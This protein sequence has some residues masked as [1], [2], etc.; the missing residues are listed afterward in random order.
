MKRIQEFFELLTQKKLEQPKHKKS[1]T[2]S[3]GL[4]EMEKNRTPRNINVISNKPKKLLDLTDQISKKKQYLI[5]IDKSFFDPNRLQ[6][7][8]KE[9][10][11]LKLLSSG[12]HKRNFMILNA[13]LKQQINPN[14]KNTNS[15]KHNVKNNGKFRK[16]FRTEFNE[17]YINIDRKH[18]FRCYTKGYFW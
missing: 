4:L 2:V 5:P 3:Q 1:L 10:S 14:P 12:S 6:E 18:K 7:I 13:F 9:S 17:K 15:T 16:F 8:L 11:V